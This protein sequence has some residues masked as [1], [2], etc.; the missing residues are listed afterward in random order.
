MQWQDEFTDE[1]GEAI[2]IQFKDCKG[3]KLLINKI[4][5]RLISN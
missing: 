2:T 1:D 3:L 4:K 5:N